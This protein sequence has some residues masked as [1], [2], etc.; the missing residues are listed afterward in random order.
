[1][2]CLNNCS[3]K[4][5]S[6]QYKTIDKIEKDALSNIFLMLPSRDLSAFSSTCKSLSNIGRNVYWDKV[7]TLPQ[8]NVEMA[9]VTSR[10]ERLIHSKDPNDKILLNNFLEKCALRNVSI[11]VNFCKNL[12][13]SNYQE[14]DK[15]QKQLKN[16]MVDL[17]NRHSSP[18]AFK[19]TIID[20]MDSMNLAIFPNLKWTKKKREKGLIPK[21]ITTFNFVELSPTM[22]SKIKVH[23]EHQFK[24]G[25]LVTVHAKTHYSAL[26]CLYYGVVNKLTENIYTL[27][28]QLTDK[29]EY[30]RLQLK[31]ACE[32]GKLPHN[33]ELPAFCTR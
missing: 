8:S 30:K 25:E 29:N 1:M 21:N 32:I 13:Q 24:T 4:L 28:L 22:A 9:V 11:Q 15:K 17:F 33:S 19:I 2:E 10:L 20:Y 5:I 7:L 31:K 26:P 14:N 27:S 23:P 16:L 6:C 12:L 18:K 3:S